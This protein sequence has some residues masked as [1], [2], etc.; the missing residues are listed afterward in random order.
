M[1]VR[2]FNRRRS[3]RRA[4]N[5]AAWIERVSTI[6]ERCVVI[7]VSDSGARLTIRDVYDL[8][9]SFAL[10]MTRTSNAGRLCRI[11]WRRDHD[12]GVEFL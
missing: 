4:A 3:A 2:F 9:E 6:L 10:H 7:N 11:V 8:P 1:N 12:V 5:Q